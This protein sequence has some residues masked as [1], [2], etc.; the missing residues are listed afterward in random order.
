MKYENKPFILLGHI[1]FT[2]CKAGLRCGVPWV[3][4]VSR[5]SCGVVLSCSPSWCGIGR[6][7]L[8]SI[9][10]IHL[11]GCILEKRYLCNTNKILVMI[12]FHRLIGPVKV[13]FFFLFREKV[14]FFFQHL[15]RE[16]WLNFKCFSITSVKTRYI[17]F[18]LHFEFWL[19]MHLTH[20]NNFCMFF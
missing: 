1:S 12:I 14:K 7:S 8:S 10:L 18:E 9:W 5:V 3:D 13:K 15:L 19:F 11:P 2:R 16:F 17:M 4:V 20:Q 6:L